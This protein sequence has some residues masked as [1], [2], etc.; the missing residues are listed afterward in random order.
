MLDAKEVIKRLCHLQE[1]VRG[2]LGDGSPAD[3]FCRTGG[4]WKSKGYGGTYKRGYRNNGTPLEFIERA[5]RAALRR[6]RKA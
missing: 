4:F 6:K 3:C 2:V 1:E 5:V